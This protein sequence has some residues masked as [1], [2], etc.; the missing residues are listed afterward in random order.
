VKDIVEYESRLNYIL[1]QFHDPVICV[2][3][4]AQFGA[5][6]VIEILRTH[7]MVIIGGILQENPF[8]VQ[9]DD[10]LKELQSHRA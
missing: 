7:P 3:D 5:A 2:Y 6:T 8:Y 10:Y 4:L 9:P 1:P